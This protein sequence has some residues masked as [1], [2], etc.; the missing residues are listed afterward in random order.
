[1]TQSPSRQ[2]G[3]GIGQIQGKNDDGWEVLDDQNEED[4]VMADSEVPMELEGSIH[5][6]E[7]DEGWEEARR[8][9]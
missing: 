9:A 8:E 6:E 3:S 7:R 4:R 1:M 5:G 2:S